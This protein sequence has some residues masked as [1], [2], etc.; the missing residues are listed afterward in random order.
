MGDE[1]SG[2]DARYASELAERERSV[3]NLLGKKDK[4]GALK[5]ALSSP[6]VATKDQDLKNRNSA[7]VEKVVSQLV[8]SDLQGCVDG[9][10]ADGLDVLMK[11]L[12]RIMA[13][14]DK[15]TNYSLLLKMH[16]MVMTK[17]GLGSIVRALADRK[18]V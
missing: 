14:I 17:S 13:N 12:Y 1:D 3:E 10:D 4:K 9:L 8:E 5:A 15:S 6:P 7:I 11:Y 16:A 2:N 18:I